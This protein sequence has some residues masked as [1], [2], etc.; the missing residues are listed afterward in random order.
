MAERV[1][2]GSAL[3]KKKPASLSW[4]ASSTV[5]NTLIT[6]I[7][8]LSEVPVN[9]CGFAVRSSLDNSDF[10]EIGF[11]RRKV[12]ATDVKLIGGA[13]SARFRRTVAVYVA[14]VI[15]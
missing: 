11:R 9:G 7:D 2:T 4:I 13:E 12:V 14:Q 1:S 5:L 6:G 8:L 3:V 10:N 15:D